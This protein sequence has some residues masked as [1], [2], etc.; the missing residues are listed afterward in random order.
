[1][2]RVNVQSSNIVSVGYDADDSMLEIEFK[3]GKVYQFNN[4]PEHI[5]EEFMSASS[6]GVYFHENIK[7]KYSYTSL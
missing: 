7:N 5:Y 6:H 4:V 1:M 2:Q 3:E